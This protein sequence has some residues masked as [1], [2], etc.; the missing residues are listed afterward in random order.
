MIKK[1]P[2]KEGEKRQLT[3]TLEDKSVSEKRTLTG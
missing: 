3:K 1:T 2:E